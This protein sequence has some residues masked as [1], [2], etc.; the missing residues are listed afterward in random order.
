MLPYKTTLTFKSGI[1]YA[2]VV[3]EKESSPLTEEDKEEIIK[4]CFN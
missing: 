4:N 1:G 3:E 2:I